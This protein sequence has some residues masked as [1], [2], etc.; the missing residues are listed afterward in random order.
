V[1]T[2]AVAALVTGVVVLAAI[3]AGV[4]VAVHG[5]RKGYAFAAAIRW[6]KPAPKRPAKAEQPA[7]G[8]S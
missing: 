8:A 3:V 7:G 6:S 4:V 2:L 5:T 1:S